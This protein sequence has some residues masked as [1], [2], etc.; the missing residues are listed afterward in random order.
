[1]K[2]A[3]TTRLAEHGAEQ[4]RQL[5]VAHPHPG[6]DD[7]QRQEEHERREERRE[8]PL[9]RVVAGRARSAP[10]GR[11][12]VAGRT[13]TFGIS[14][15]SRSI[16]DRSTST[17]AKTAPTTARPRRSRSG[18]STRRRGRGSTTA[19]AICQRPRQRAHESRAPWRG[20]VRRA[21]GLLVSLSSTLARLSRDAG[22]PSGSVSS[23]VPLLRH[24]EP[25]RPA[26][27]LAVAHDDARRR[28]D[29]A[30]RCAATVRAA[31]PSE[32]V[33]S[34]TTTSG[35]WRSTRST[36]LGPR[37]SSTR[38][39]SGCASAGSARAAGS[40]RRR[41]RGARASVRRR[42]RRPG[43]TDAVRRLR[44]GAGGR[45][46]RAAHVS[47]SARLEAVRARTRPRASSTTSCAPRQ[48]AARHGLRLGD[49]P[50][51]RPGR[52]R[53]RRRRSGSA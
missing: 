17:A 53:R 21:G 32:S 13:I 16:A 44:R 18:R 46:G 33:A 20:R 24:L 6:R 12:A 35:S 27:R 48:V 43:L 26:R 14:R 19:T 10:R 42:A 8:H 45:S 9:E 25:G 31:S 28:W 7:E 1:M 5:D 30:P 39:R 11:T 22:C 49:D 40:G 36:A 29:A 52:R 37:A 34:I 38:P 2:I 50:A 47:R 15:R 41:S 3:A 51:A 4:R 23:A